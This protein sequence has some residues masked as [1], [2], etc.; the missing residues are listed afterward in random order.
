[1]IR[2][3]CKHAVIAELTKDESV[4]SAQD[5]VAKAVY[6]APIALPRVQ[7]ISLT[8]NVQSVDV[9]ADDWTDV[10]SRCAGYNGSIK[11]DFLSPEDAR[12]MLGERQVNGIN[13]ATSDDVQKYFALGFM[14]QIKGVNS[15][16]NSYSYFW[17]LKTKFTQSETTSSSA[18]TNNLTP[19]ADS[20][21]FSS[22]NRECDNAWRFYAVSDEPNFANT[23]FTQATLQT[24]A[25][26]A[27]Q[28]YSNPV[29]EVV[30]ADVLPESG[31]AGKIYIVEN[32]SYYWNGTEFVKNGEQA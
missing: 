15:T 10:I 24:L 3:G 21:S 22:T 4:I 20:L 6:A 19:Q 7:E 27:E 30:F 23:F 12:I 2:V 5:G 18:G 11:R 25:N 26:A 14:S 9:D 1:M 28:T 32:V 31:D 16:P 8:P 29:S 17:V 13:V